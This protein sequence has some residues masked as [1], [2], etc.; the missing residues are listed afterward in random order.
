MKLPLL[1]GEKIFGQY[2]KYVLTPRCQW[3]S[4]IFCACKNLNEI[5]IQREITSS[6]NGLESWKN[7]GQKSRYNFPFSQLKTRHEKSYF[8]KLATLIKRYSTRMMFTPIIHINGIRVSD[9]CIKSS[10]F[11]HNDDTTHWPTLAYYTFSLVEN[12]GSTV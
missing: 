4:E 7:G 12:K 1:T 3:H 9:V 8:M 6:Y 10:F 5:G 11:C 2:Q